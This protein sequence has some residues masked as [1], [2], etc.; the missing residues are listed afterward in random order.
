MNLNE[1]GTRIKSARHEARLTQEQL[2]ELIDVSPHYIYEI[3]RGSKAMS[4]QTLEKLSIALHQSIDF[5]FWG[6]SMP[7]SKDSHSRED[8]LSMLTNNLPKES[9]NALADIL[10]VLIPYLKAK[11]EK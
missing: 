10:T 1:I 7:Y 2:A 3:E 4:I 11:K 6:N 8:R 5:L 9:R